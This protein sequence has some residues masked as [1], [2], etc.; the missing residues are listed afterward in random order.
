METGLVFYCW[1]VKVIDNRNVNRYVN[2]HTLLS[3]FAYIERN[4]H[5]EELEINRY[6]EQ[7]LLSRFALV[8]MVHAAEE[9]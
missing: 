2:H 6:A 1:W 8:I 3:T 7:V 9:S 5:K 4:T